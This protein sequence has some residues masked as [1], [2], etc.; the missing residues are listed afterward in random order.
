MFCNNFRFRSAAARPYRE[1]SRVV[2]REKG[3]KKFQ[4][5]CE[6]RNSRRAAT[7]EEFLKI[8]ELQN[9]ISCSAFCFFCLRASYRRT[10]NTTQH[11]ERAKESEEARN[12]KISSVER[13]Y[14][15]HSMLF[16]STFS[17][18]FEC[19]ASSFPCLALKGSFVAVPWLCSSSQ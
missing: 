13:V 11:H 16:F 9:V 6:R 4:F 19:F 18:S 7:K 2:R 15:H 17:L 12:S 1:T 5:R 3:Q 10:Q 14:E 8:K